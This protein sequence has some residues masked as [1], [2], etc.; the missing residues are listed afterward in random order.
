MTA[1]TPNEQMNPAL[2]RPP[3]GLASGRSVKSAGLASTATSVAA[4][5]SG[6]PKVPQGVIAAVKP[7]ASEA[8]APVAAASQPA[9]VPPTP[10]RVAEPEAA[11][12]AVADATR[13]S[14]SEIP[15]IQKETKDSIMSTTEDFINHGQANVEAVMKSG[16]IWATGMQDLGRTF[17]ESAQAQFDHTVATWKALAGTK[18]VKEAFDIQSTRARA[19]LEKAV[20]DTGRL[21]DASMKLAEQ[22]MAPITARLSVATEKFGAVEKFARQ[23]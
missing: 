5:T 22:A 12:T 6:L 18:S 14:V 19:S 7:M 1:E 21:T 4:V 11:L 15:E 3:S 17:V 10:P 9:S 20:A 8:P 16:Q 2:P 13:A 23:N